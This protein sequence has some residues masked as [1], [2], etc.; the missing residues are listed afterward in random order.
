MA[1]V[2]LKTLGFYMILS[3]VKGDLPALQKPMGFRGSKHSTAGCFFCGCPHSEFWDVKRCRHGAQPYP[4]WTTEEMWEMKREYDSPYAK[5]CRPEV[6][7]FLYCICTQW[8]LA[9]Q[10]NGAHM[11]GGPSEAAGI[12]RQ[13]VFRSKEQPVYRWHN[14]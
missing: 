14:T 7:F 12:T 8:V 2:S 3:E 4:D 10:S 11:H 1:H 6:C 13:V 5:H 9:Q